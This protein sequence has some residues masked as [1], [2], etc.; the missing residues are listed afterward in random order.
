MGLM[1][2]GSF[3][4][5]PVGTTCKS[6]IEHKGKIYE[7]PTQIIREATEEEYRQWALDDGGYT[8]NDI[9]DRLDWAHSKGVPVMFYQISVD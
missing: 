7:V 2:I 9:Q 8:E 1:I 6:A 4:P 5:W 3:E